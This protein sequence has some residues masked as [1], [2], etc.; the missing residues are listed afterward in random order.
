[1]GLIGLKKL[2]EYP[3]MHLPLSIAKL[4]GTLKKTSKYVLLHKLEGTV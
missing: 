4:D 1:L 2:F 3:L